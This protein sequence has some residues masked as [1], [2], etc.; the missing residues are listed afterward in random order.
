MSSC[1][2]IEY[3]K[4][5]QNK[6]IILPSLE[7]LYADYCPNLRDMNLNAS[8]LNMLHAAHCPNL[9]LA[10][11]APV[12]RSVTLSGSPV[13]GISD[14]TTLKKLN[15]EKSKVT[16]KELMPILKQNIFEELNLNGCL[17]IWEALEYI[18]SMGNKPKRLNIK[19]TGPAFGKACWESY[20]GVDIGEEPPL[21][22]DIFEQLSAKCPLGL[23]PAFG[24]LMW[25]THVLVLVPSHIT[26]QGEKDTKEL[27]LKR[28]ER[29]IKHKLQA[30]SKRYF[31][32]EERTHMEFYHY[33]HNKVCVEK[34][35]WILLS[36]GVLKDSCGKSYSA[37]VR[38]VAEL[39]SRSGI[40]YRVP[41]L[42]EVCVA[43]YIHHIRTGETLYVNHPS[44]C[45]RCQEGLSA[46]YPTVAKLGTYGGRINW[47]YIKG[48]V[49]AV[50]EVPYVG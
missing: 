3:L 37:Q 28:L 2:K 7:Y 31:G 42:I 1:K 40:N 27:T 4:E 10:L 16:D 6:A 38:Q 49:G 24:D 50:W 29:L 26:K 45:M 22:L 36:K 13:T 44:T 46:S 48:G 30:S 33:N 43:M 20:F 39:A 25:Q 47:G 21:P 23:D 12:L 19:E 15:L 5:G 34:N 41:K 14:I 9:Q 11:E 8:N 35:T 32:E 18:E 17:H